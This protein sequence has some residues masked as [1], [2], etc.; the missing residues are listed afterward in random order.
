[1]FLDRDGVINEDVDHLGQVSQLR[2]LPGAPDAL[3]ALQ[4]EFL[5]VVVTNQ[6]G[7]AKGLFTE[8][9]LFSVHS[10][11]VAQLSNEGVVIDALFYCPH[12]QDAAVQAYAQICEC[13]KPKPGM[14][15]KAKNQWGL[16][17]NES[18]MIGDRPSDI[19]AGQRAGVKCIFLGEPSQ[20]QVPEA[21]YAS[22]LADAANLILA[23]QT[24]VST[25]IR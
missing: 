13:R 20:L 24:P 23:G 12:H 17:M 25:I 2:L 9:A 3:R 5:L 6:S 18:Y 16:D 7:I 8:E 4:A 10:E 22:D 21:Q 15:L 1:M 11:I 19:Q 14:L